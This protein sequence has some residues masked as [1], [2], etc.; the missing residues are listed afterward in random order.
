M[1]LTI[2]H[3]I[4]C[5]VCANWVRYL[6]TARQVRSKARRAGW[7]RRKNLDTGWMEDV[8]P[9]CAEKAKEKT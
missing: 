5:D 8:C 9:S 6:G 2:E 3:T 1:S 4:N 7:V